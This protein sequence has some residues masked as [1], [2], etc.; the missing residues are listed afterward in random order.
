MR[1]GRSSVK[2]IVRKTTCARPRFR[3]H[4]AAGGFGQQRVTQRR[5]GH[6]GQ[7]DTWTHISSQILRMLSRKMDRSRSKS[8]K[9]RGRKK[10]EQR[11]AAAN[12]I[13]KYHIRLVKNE[14]ALDTVF[15]RS[16][17]SLKVH[18]L[19]PVSTSGL[20][21]CDPYIRVPRLDI[22]FSSSKG[23][24]AGKRARQLCAHG[25]KN[26]YRAPLATTWLFPRP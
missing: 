14:S 15:Q 22:D 16:A 2:I 4:C 8:F 20:G 13:D 25:N 18:I 1:D 11:A 10:K 7:F 24:R 3:A 5:C 9:D 12:A 6:C 17:Q 23:H 19:V 21:H 26:V